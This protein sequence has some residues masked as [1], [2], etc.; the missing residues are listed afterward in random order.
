MGEWP[1]ALLMKAEA[2]PSRPERR[3]SSAI[4]NKPKLTHTVFL[5]LITRISPFTTF[6]LPHAVVNYALSPDLV[7]QYRKLD[8]QVVTRL[9]RANAQLRDEARTGKHATAD[10]MCAKMWS[11]VMGEFGL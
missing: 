5:R 2:P 3:Y 4:V 6:P 9:N 10:G 8:D 7:R 11:E 1:L